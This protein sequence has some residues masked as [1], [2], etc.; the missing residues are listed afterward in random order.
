MTAPV[1][2]RRALN[3]ALLERQLL[4]GRHARSA[5]DTI[6]HLVAMQAQEPHAPHVGLWTRLAGFEPTRRRRP[7]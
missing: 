5:A 3:R 7:H 2:T 6:E 4:L 1:L